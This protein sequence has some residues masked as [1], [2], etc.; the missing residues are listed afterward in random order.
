M[1]A[2]S[3]RPDHRQER[4]VRLLT[5]GA[6]RAKKVRTR[7]RKR[8]VHLL[9]FLYHAAAEATNNRAERALQPAVIARTLSCGNKTLR[10]RRTW[11]ILTSLA[12]TCQQRGE[13]FVQFLRPQHTLAPAR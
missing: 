2:V 3:L 7:L 11:E 13:D 5:A 10:G 9:T 6:G 8:R 4:G 1:S 12:A